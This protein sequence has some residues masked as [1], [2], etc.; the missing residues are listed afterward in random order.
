MSMK[1]TIVLMLTAAQFL[2]LA[3]CDAVQ[4][5]LDETDGD[6]ASINDGDESESDGEEPPADGDDVGDGDLTPDGDMA[7]ADT[8]WTDGDADNDED[9]YLDGDGI[10]DGDADGDED[11]DMDVAEMAWVHLPVEIDDPIMQGTS[12]MLPT[13][14]A[15]F[16]Y[17]AADDRFITLYGRDYFEPEIA[18]IWQVDGWDGTHSKKFL[19]GN[20]FPEGENFCMN[21]NWCQFIDFDPQNG[22]LVILG[23]L[24]PHIMHVDSDLIAS[25][26]D[27]DGS[28]PSNSAI[29]FSHVFDWENRVLYVYG[30]L[31]P[32]DFGSELYKVDLDTGHWAKIAT[33]LPAVYD[34]CL[35]LDTS[36]DT[37]Y[38]FGG[39]S[40]DDGGDTSYYLSSYTAVNLSDFSHASFTMP[41]LIGERR[42]MSCTTDSARELIYLFA[43]AKVVDN[44]DETLN[45]YHNDLWGFDPDDGSFEIMMPDSDT[46]YFE[47]PDQW[48]TSFVGYPSGPN[49][50]KNRAYLSHDETNNRLILA[51]QVPVFTGGQ[52]YLLPLPE[53]DR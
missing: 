6:E 24:S 4:D 45:D 16:S 29:T 44:Y 27:T 7:D 41:E 50:G 17:D 31:L 52:L 38:S 15:V 10:E 43:G 35:A 11:G 47:E 8:N 2:L 12:L 33:A 46:G 25:L 1:S 30:M 3:G 23:P 13:D 37:L 53:G 48:G 49:F 39:S 21:E 5:L 14:N 9:F 32:Y 36:G 18:F 26:T 51:G 28:Q 42:A 40:S 22:D 20:I 34:N 19:T